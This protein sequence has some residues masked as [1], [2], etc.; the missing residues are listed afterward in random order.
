M[1]RSSISKVGQEELGVIGKEKCIMT[2]FVQLEK[3][4]KAENKLFE[5]ESE[6]W[7]QQTICTMSSNSGVKGGREG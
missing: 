2:V 3:V 6:K 5:Q 4:K 7:S 1:A